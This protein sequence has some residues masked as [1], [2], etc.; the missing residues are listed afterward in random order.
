MATTRI[1]FDSF[2]LAWHTLWHRSSAPR[3]PRGCMHLRGNWWLLH[4]AP[5]GVCFE[6]SRYCLDLCLED[7]LARALQRTPPLPRRE[8]PAHRLP[9]GLLLLSRQQLSPELLQAGLNAQRAAGHG[10]LGEWLRALGFVTEV[11]VASA[12]AQQWS[13]PMLRTSSSF[14]AERSG[15]LIPASLLERFSMVPVYYVEPTSTLYL[16]FSEEPS[17]TALYSIERMTDCHTQACFATPTF[18]HAQLATLHHGRRENEIVFHHVPEIAEVCGI[19]RSYCSRLGA[20]QIRMARCGSYLWVRL[21]RNSRSPL[22]LILHA[23]AA[24]G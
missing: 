5:A 17:Y 19:V 13:C 10:R 20:A 15:P 22:D 1:P 14:M 12:L 9:L 7:A 2:S 21:V 8:A 23:S 16:A 24:V 6:N 18:V 4:S 3:K 11:Q